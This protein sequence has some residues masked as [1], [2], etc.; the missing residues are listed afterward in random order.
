[1]PVQDCEVHLVDV[2][3]AAQMLAI[4]PRGVWRLAKTGELP[5]PVHVGRSA[6]WRVADLL[7]YIY[8]HDF[9]TEVK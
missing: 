1:M 6:R 8:V 4:S 3:G 7:S 2:R 9:E 5:Q